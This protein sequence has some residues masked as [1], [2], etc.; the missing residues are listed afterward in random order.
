MVATSNPQAA[1]AGLDVLKAGGNAVD[2]AIAAAAMLA[3]I[4]PTQTGIGGD[5]FAIL[6]KPGAEPVALNGSGWAAA[7]AHVEYF[8][9]RGIQTLDPRSAH[10]VTVPGAVRAWER[11]LQDHGTFEFARLLQPA[12]DAAEHGYAVTERLA[13]D[14]ARQIAKLQS[15]PA[16]AQTFLVDGAAPAAGD[17]RS[18][19]ALAKALKS[20]ALEGS[21]IFYRGWIADDIVS[22]LNRLGG[23]HVPADFAE[24]QP[25]YA[26]PIST[27]YRDYDLWECPPN[28]Q[29]ITALIIA[30]ILDRFDLG[31][32]DPLSFERFHLQAE[33]ARLAYA[34][35]DLFVCD[36]AFQPV[37]TADLLRV[38]RISDLARK[39]TL[40]GRISDVSPTPLPNQRDT[41]YITAVDQDGTA[42]SFINSLFDNFGSG[43]VA[44]R[45]G[46]LLHNRGTGF[47]LIP[48]H[49]NV[50]AGRKRPMHT[51]IPALLTKNGHTVLSFGVT[52]GHFQPAGQVQVLSNII[53]Y[54]MSV[55]QAIDFP[56]MFARGDS[57]ALEST[58]PIRIENALRDAG[59]RPNR[60][61]D[62]LGTAHA[63]WIDQ[64]NGVLRGGSDPRR[65][66]IAVGY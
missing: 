58:V 32:Y 39:V 34:Q 23:V 57:L 54:G 13:Y 16:A 17:I 29:G 11:L 33:I 37:P 53:D 47:V 18:N 65:D 61:A 45:C 36:P 31:R 35:R 49:A 3:V 42:V 15:T 25:Q 20:I 44:P 62:P 22:T 52:G 21:D 10:A 1:L 26:T 5:C 43:L 51:I 60:T 46:V 50:L 9:E 55:Q 19:P 14:W 28:G 48:G 4:E 63:I 56:R 24:Y 66:G 12:I 40:E 64:K 6:K 41:V 7:A 30:S 2:A 59:H 27:R 8:V 38:D